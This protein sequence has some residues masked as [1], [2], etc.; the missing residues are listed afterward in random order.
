ME[1]QKSEEQGA[2]SPDL[3][4]TDK[5][6]QFSHYLGAILDVMTRVGDHEKAGGLLDKVLLKLQERAEAGD[7]DAHAFLID[8][9]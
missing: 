7:R 8:L 5:L 4:K 1:K 9:V 3:S 6:I 2:A